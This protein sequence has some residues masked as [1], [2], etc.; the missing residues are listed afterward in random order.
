MSQ[1]RI[2]V[3]GAGGFVG[4]KLVRRLYED[5]HRNILAVTHGV[6]PKEFSKMEDSVETLHG[7]LQD[8]EFAKLALYQAKWVYNLAAKV[9]GINYIKD[10]H[11]ECLLSAQINM[12]L[13]RAA[14]QEKIAGYFFASSACVYG[15]APKGR[16]IS[17]SEF[18]DPSPGY[19]DEK[20]FSEKVCIAFAREYNLPIKIGRYHTI[21]GPGDDNKS[22]KDHVQT[23]LCKKVIDARLNGVHEICIWGDGEQTRSHLYID[24]CV[25]ATIRLMGCGLASYLPMNI[26]HRKAHSINEM[27]TMLEDIAAIKLLRFYNDA[28]PVGVQHRTSN[29]AWIRE[30]LHWEPTTPLR[31]G[32][33]KLYRE[34]WEQA[35]VKK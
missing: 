20:L 26:A 32:L 23:S 12:N 13:L 30:I 21:Y 8:I 24:D 19:G 7:D 28:A 1:E 2:V 17:E 10:F 35:T 33:A 6:P 11:A 18:I 22:G 15:D 14:L 16:L 5:G 29:N 4:R 27:V 3:C 9:G 25:E 31:D 34:L